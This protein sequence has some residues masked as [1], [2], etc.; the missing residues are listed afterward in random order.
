MGSQGKDSLLVSSSADIR[1]K[2]NLIPLKE[3]NDT[4]RQD[5]RALVQETLKLSLSCGAEVMDK[6]L[7]GARKRKR[8]KQPLESSAFSS[9]KHDCLH[10]KSKAHAATSNDI[11]AY[12]DDRSVLQHRNNIMLCVTEGDM[13]SQ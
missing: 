4:M 12:K 13:E 11:L 7:A 9:S 5:D 3:R 1:G 10:L 8:A 2:Q 6:T